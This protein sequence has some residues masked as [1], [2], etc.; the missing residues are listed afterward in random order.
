ME[1]SLKSLQNELEFMRE[2]HKN[3]VTKITTEK[4]FED[5]EEE[6]IGGKKRMMTKLY[7]SMK[8]ISDDFNGMIGN[9]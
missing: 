1:R 4:I 6:A 3:L 2:K 9:W 5:N 7:D 8:T